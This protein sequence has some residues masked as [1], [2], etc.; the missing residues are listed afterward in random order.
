MPHGPDAFYPFQDQDPPMLESI[1]QATQTWLAKVILVVITVP[2]ALWGIESYVKNPTGQDTVAKVGKEEIGSAEFNDAVR[3]QLEQFKRQFG[4]QIDASIMDNPQMRESILQ[5]LVDQR[6]FVKASEAAGVKL[7]DAALRERIA[8]EATFQENGQFSPTRYQTYLKASG[9]SALQFEL[10]M[11]KDIERGQFIGSVAN[12]GFIAKASVEGFLK[13]SE[14]SREIAMVNINPEQFSAGVKI[15]PEQAKLDYEQNKAA[16]TIPEQARAEYV[17]LSIDALAPT[18]QVT[19]EEIKTYYEANSSRFVQKEERK[20]SHILINAAKDAK[21]EVKKAAKEKADQLFAQVRKDPKSFAEVAR[22]NSQDTGSAPGGG[23]LGFFGRG[24]MV[25]PFEEAAFAAR[26]DDIVGP[27]LSDFGY[28][29]IQIRDVRPE[30][31]KSVAEA[32]PEIEGELKKQKAQRKFAEVAEKFSTAAYEQS[33]SLKAA[34]EVAGL[35]IK[36]S[37]FIV[38]G[39]GAPP[40]NN[41]KLAAALFSDEVLKNKRNT[42]AVETSPNTLVVA[43]LL[44]SKPAVVRPFAEVEKGIINKLTREEAGKLAKKDGEAKLAALKEGKPVELKWPALLAVSRANPGGLPPPVIDAA[45]KLDAKKLPGY[46][47]TENPGGGY[48][49]VQVAKVLEA[50]LSDE[51]KLKAAR[52]RVAQTMTQQEVMAIVADA[53]T[54]T[55]VTIVKAALEKKDK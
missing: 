22:K 46:A 16:Y 36:Q 26:K 50:P 20:A 4:G 52:T 47:G 34:A 54:K 27:V 28:H 44:E 1:R 55:N 14:Q 32:T 8:S 23:D 49:I 21:D 51:T 12:T 25:K 17:E 48:T 9:Q 2:F 15:T 3:N 40:F 35:A 5:Q 24:A 29:I 39:G 6:L 37:A 33:A 53:R 38:K 30:K 11:R 7:S 19:A 13:A 31:G 10:A 42:E 45:M 18:V 41:P 43:R